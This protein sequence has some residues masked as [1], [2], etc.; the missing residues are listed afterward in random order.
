MAK[1]LTAKAFDYS[2]LEKDTKSKLIWLAGAIRKANATHAKAGIEIGQFLADSRDLLADQK[3]FRDWVEKETCYSV[4]SAYNYISAFEHFGACA[5][6]AHIE[7][8]AMYV[9]TSNAKAKTKAIKLADNGVSVTHSMAKKLVK[10]SKP[11]P[12]P[13]PP[14]PP[15]DSPD[16]KPPSEPDSPP[17]ASPAKPRSTPPKKLDKPAYYKQWDQAIG[18]LVR[19]VSQIADGVGEK[20]GQDHRAVKEHLNDATKAMMKWMGAKQ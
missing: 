4:R 16:P 6:F 11:K 15:K 3:P 9:L 19:L 17:K 18:P 7:L 13:K 14:K 1:E 8:S 12:T 2:A 10:E 20:N 5:N